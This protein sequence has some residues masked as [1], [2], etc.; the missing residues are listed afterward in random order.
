[1]TWTFTE[2]LAAFLDAAGPALTADPLANTLLLTTVDSLRR[3]GPNAFGPCPPYFAG[4]AGAD[5]AVSA[6]LVCTPPNPLLVGALPA[7]ALDALAAV[8]HT[9]PLLA[10][11]SGFNARSEDAEVLA[12]AW[13]RPVEAHQERLFRLDA[14]VA[15]AP[16]PA[17]S[18]RPAAEEDV[19]LLL[20]WLAAFAAEA[21]TPAAAEAWARDRISYGGILLWRDAAG[22]PV[23]LASF[24]R[25]QASTARVGPVYTPPGERG[26]GY[27]AGATH[28]ATL[29]ARAAGA[30]EVLLFTDLAN[31]T[32]NRLYPRLGYAPLWD[33][34]VITARAGA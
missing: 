3:R 16:A 19:P 13:G 20:E 32:S 24:S 21:G 9:E 23:S 29:A 2:D 33:R 14:P 17:G 31:P 30:A 22:T 18:S 8:L 5:G 4:W 1:M 11:V 15:P 27:A 12:A 28:A 7:E 34:S 6:V 26:H 25:P 10:E